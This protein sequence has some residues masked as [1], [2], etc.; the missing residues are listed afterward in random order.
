MVPKG[1]ST[2]TMDM[3]VAVLKLRSPVRGSGIRPTG[4]CTKSWQAGATVKVSGWGL[5]SENASNVP[6]QV[7]TVNVSAIAK[8]RCSELYRRQTSLTK[9]MFCASIPGLKDSCLGDSGGPAFINGQ[10]CGVVSWGIG[11]ARKAY[12]GVYTSVLAVRKFIVNAMKR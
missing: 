7:R 5:T 6:T 10:F 1:F 9:S 2:S 3:D 8:S 12:P 4:L 11:C